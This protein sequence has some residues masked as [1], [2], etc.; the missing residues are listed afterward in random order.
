MGLSFPVTSPKV[1]RHIPEEDLFD[2][3]GKGHETD[4]RENFPSPSDDVGQD[5]RHTEC[6]E[7]QLSASQERQR[8]RRNKK[9]VAVQTHASDLKLRL[10][11][12]SSESRDFTRFAEEWNY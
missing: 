3:P 7:E 6:Y 9:L 8:N 1:S 12:S 11:T 10:R 4:N 2:D 5:A